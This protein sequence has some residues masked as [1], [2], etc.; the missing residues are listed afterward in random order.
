MSVKCFQLNMHHAKAATDNLRVVI[1]EVKSS[2]IAFLQEP[3]IKHGR[4]VGFGNQGTTVMHCPI[5]KEPNRAALNLSRDLQA[6][7]LTHIMSRDIAAALVDINGKKFIIAS[8]YMP[9]DSA[10]HPTT[11]VNKLVKYSEDNQLNIIICADANSHHAL[12]G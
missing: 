10:D 3:Y 6:W 9:F 1:S 5:P 8:V 7:P 2:Y 4:L 12:W 11:G